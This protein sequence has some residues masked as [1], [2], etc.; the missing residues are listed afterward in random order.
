MKIHIV[1]KGDTF[2]KIAKKYGVDVEQLKSLNTHIPNMEMLLPGMKVK[3]P[4]VKMPVKKEEVVKEVK[5]EKV[6]EEIKL[7]FPELPKQPMPP[8]MHHPYLSMN[9]YQMQPYVYYQPHLMMPPKECHMPPVVPAPAPAPS[10]AAVAPFTPPELPS[11]PSMEEIWHTEKEI[12]VEEELPMAEEVPPMPPLPNLEAMQPVQ[13]PVQQ[14]VP[15]APMMM[16]YHPP[17]PECFPPMVPAHHPFVGYPMPSPCG[18]G[19][20][21]PMPSPC[22]CGGS[23]PMA[24]PPVMYPYPPMPQPY[25][26]PMQ[27][28]QQPYPA[29]PPPATY[30]EAEEEEEEA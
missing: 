30:R 9:L 20:P 26:Y 19:G 1:Q 2:Y 22:G 10:P 8:T 4:T 23:N 18:C 7:E 6:M 21:A 11:L 3:I 29:S 5:K 17:H 13:Q 16:P 27:P 25:G 14:P 24:Y 15:A 28:V 12:C